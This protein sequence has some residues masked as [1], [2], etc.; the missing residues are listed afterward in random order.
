MAAILYKL[1]TIFCSKNPFMSFIEIKKMIFL[2]M[3]ITAILIDLII[4]E[5]R[6]LLYWSV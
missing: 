5:R 4:S 1:E 2:R 6:S 3:F